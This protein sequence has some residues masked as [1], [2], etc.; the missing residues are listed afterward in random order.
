MNIPSAV[1]EE[2]LTTVS[3]IVDGISDQPHRNGDGNE[4][5]P[6]ITAATETVPWKFSGYQMDL[7]SFPPENMAMESEDALISNS[8]EDMCP[9]TAGSMDGS[10]I[11]EV[12]PTTESQMAIGIDSSKVLNSDDSHHRYQQLTESDMKRY[13]A[14]SDS[15]TEWYQR[16]QLKK[17]ALE[18]DMASRG[19]HLT[20][21]EV[22]NLLSGY[23]PSPVTSE[24][25][26]DIKTSAATIKTLTATDSRPINSVVAPILQ[27]IAR[28][29]SI[30]TQDDGKQRRSARAKRKPETYAQPPS[31]K[32]TPPKKQPVKSSK[33]KA[34]SN[35]LPQD[36]GS[37]C[38]VCGKLIRGA[39]EDVHR[40]IQSHID[41]TTQSRAY[42]NNNIANNLGDDD[43][44]F[45][46]YEWAGETRVR[47]ITGLQANFHALGYYT[48][49]SSNGTAKDVADDLDVD[50]DESILYGLPQFSQ[51]DLIPVDNSYRRLSS[52]EAM[53][54]QAA[55]LR[56]MAEAANLNK[57]PP[58]VKEL[59]RKCAELE[60]KAR[61]FSCLV[62]MEQ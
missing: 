57:K 46:T 31:P 24:R 62:C 2:P 48:S 60:T 26:I 35:H 16:Q 30:E 11:A 49:G 28:R 40:H 32:R 50:G 56:A 58:T 12:Q 1:D 59:K 61:K 23:M 21:G 41:L 7:E 10:L 36:P 25:K 38:T 33:P 18:L 53:L 13:S 5:S 17:E 39:A 9:L 3:D 44:E 34:K 22:E 37:D 15:Q 6:I 27:D 51:A 45:E 4:R 52:K 19:Y 20:P 29:E 8:V 55:E 42:S 54:K 47:A 14:S 43:E